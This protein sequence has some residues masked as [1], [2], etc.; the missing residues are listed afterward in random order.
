MKR[1][2][3]SSLR[4]SASHL[5]GLALLATFLTLAPSLATVAAPR[6]GP[7]E[8]IVGRTVALRISKSHYE[9]KALN[10][11]VSAELLNEYFKYLDRQH[12]FFLASDV[13][14]FASYKEV[15]DDQLLRGNVDF[16][17][18][19]YERFLERLRERVEYVRQR[20]DQDFDFTV[21]EE[22]TYDRSEESWCES[23]AEMDELWRLRLKHNYLNYALMEEP[24]EKPEPEDKPDEP[25]PEAPK[26]GDGNGG[27][28]T[29]AAPDTV[30]PPAAETPKPKTPGE[31]VIKYYEDYLQ[32]MEAKDGMDILE[33]YLTTLAHLFDPHSA[34]MAPSTEEDFDIQMKLSLQGIGALLTTEDGYIKVVEVIPGGPAMMDGRLGAGDRITGVAQEAQEAVDVV[35]MPLRKVVSMIR[36]EKGTKVFLTVIKAEKGIG[37]VPVTIDI[38]RDEVKLTEKEAKAETLLLDD[39]GETIE[40]DTEVEPF[41]KVLLINL[42]SF[43][44]DF[45]GRREG[46]DDYKSA[47]GDLRKL[48]AESGADELSGVILDLRSNGGGG[49]DEAVRVAG[50]FFPEGPVVQTRYVGGR[51]KVLSDTEEDTVFAGPLIVLVDRLSA[52]A[53]EIVAAAIQDY[54]RGVVIGAASTHGKGTVQT[55][56]HLDREFSRS[57]ILRGK[58][59]GSIKFTV[60]KFYRING[61]ATQLKGVEPD[62]TF[63]S[64][65]DH[66]EMGESNLPRALAW[67]SIEPLEFAPHNR[68][69]PYLDTLRLRSTERRQLDEDYLLYLKEVE[70][71]G[72]RR[73][74]KAVSLNREKRVAERKEQ[75]E[76]SERIKRYGGRRHRPKDDDEED[77]DNKVEEGE[78]LDLVFDESLRVLA[79]LVRLGRGTELPAIAA[80]VPSPSPAGADVG[81]VQETTTE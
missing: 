32:R 22:Y 33:M 25:T 7:L 16:A 24:A 60:G 28:D 8:R 66:M 6:P 36:G 14:Q 78:R 42:P 71:Y 30:D 40:G 45:E 63:P 20:L 51:K 55:L 77:D 59:A 80:T 19:V 50:L 18:D 64:F 49:L 62:I 27:A 35:D 29:D 3:T 81:V 76:F 37:S 43:Y 79:D 58:K 9:R 23:R 67:D 38:V 4:C 69:T 65:A 74:R 70:E 1:H 75:D 10:N 21:D 56:H 31:R 26:D 13:E 73:N 53:S 44:C 39:N 46:K 61:G 72:E 52:S 47:S 41:A 2:T 48:L 15:L 68:V 34:Y 11:D 57:P 12:Y 17:Y 54:G 5:R